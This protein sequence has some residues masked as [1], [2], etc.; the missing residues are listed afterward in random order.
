MPVSRQILYPPRLWFILFSLCLALAA[1][2]L[3]ALSSM[4]WAPD[5]LLLTLMYWGL[6]QPRRVGFTVVF[7][8]GLLMD[9]ANGQ[10]LG[11]YALA[12]VLVLF[13]LLLLQRRLLMLSLWA[14]ALHAGGLLLLAC[15]VE[16]IIRLLTG[17]KLPGWTWFAPPL[18]GL[19]LW[20]GLSLV[21]QLPQRRAPTTHL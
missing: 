2:L 6:Y 12:Y 10:L 3:P 17:G 21:L 9:V 1:N 15:V 13:V 11:Q 18:V 16:A 7:L 5:W 20:P 4:R 8:C 14:Q 19:L